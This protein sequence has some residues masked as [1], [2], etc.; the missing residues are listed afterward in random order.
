MEGPVVVFI[1]RPHGDSIQPGAF[2]FRL[3][4]HFAGGRFGYTDGNA[5]FGPFY[6]RFVF[7]RQDYR[8]QAA[9]NSHGRGRGNMAY[10]H[11]GRI[12]RRQ[13]RLDTRKRNRP[14]YHHLRGNLLCDVKAH[15]KVLHI[16]YHDEMDVHLFNTLA[17]AV[18]L[19]RMQR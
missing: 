7:W 18:F 9:W 3:A 13:F 15:D 5:V 11:G 19:Q 17:L 16:V 12:A 10:N 14:H 1:F 2:Y 6:I 8:A 4:P